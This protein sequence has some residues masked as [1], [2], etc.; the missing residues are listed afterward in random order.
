MDQEN[1][2]P[3]SETRLWRRFELTTRCEKEKEDLERVLDEKHLSRQDL[4]T[5]LFG[6]RVRPEYQRSDFGI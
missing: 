2:N 4:A 1:Q 3:S 6:L 5:I